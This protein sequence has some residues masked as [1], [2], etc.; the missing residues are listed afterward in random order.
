[1]AAVNSTKEG[2]K[3]FNNGTLMIMTLKMKRNKKGKFQ[4]RKGH[5]GPEVEQRYSS[6]LS[7]TSALDTTGSLTPR[8]GRFRS[9]EWAPGPVWTGSEN[10]AVTWIRSPVRPARSESLYGLRYRGPRT[11]TV[12]DLTTGMS[13]VK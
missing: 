7:L 2:D 1:M 4:P 3:D 11:K 12:T 9:E 5:E 13:C 6:T 10:V 8:P